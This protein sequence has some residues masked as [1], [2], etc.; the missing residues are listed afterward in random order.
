MIAL[1]DYGAGNLTSVRKG[2][3]AAGAE[4]FTPSRPAELAR[5]TAVVVPGVGHF[6]AAAR[7]AGDWRTAIADA[8]ALG[9]PL[10]GICLGMQWLFDGSDEAPGVPGLGAISGKCH[11]LRGGVEQ[12]HHLKVP[13]VGWNVLH[14]RSPSRLPVSTGTYVYFTHSYAAPDGSATVASCSHGPD[15]FA[16][17]VETGNVFGV[18]F[19]PEKSGPAGVRLLERFV[20]IVREHP[21]AV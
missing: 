8:V 20:S 1:I 19:H 16:A 3:A 15:Q 4:L 14:Q 12:G 11:R 13:H 9:K 18:Q 10:L 21:H 6:N 7:L 17:V 5:A 2:F